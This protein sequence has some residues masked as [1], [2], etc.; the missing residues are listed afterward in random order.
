MHWEI[1]KKKVSQGVR[2]RHA[3]VRVRVTVVHRLRTPTFHCRP[4]LPP[5]DAEEINFLEASQGDQML[6]PPSV[7]HSGIYN[8]S[9]EGSCL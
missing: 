4:P 1:L 3:Q 8:F 5:L 7:L 9:A 2:G 6:Y